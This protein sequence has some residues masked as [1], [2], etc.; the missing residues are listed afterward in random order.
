MGLVDAPA[1][2]GTTP[3]AMAA[4]AQFVTRN[5]QELCLPIAN[6]LMTHL[7]ATQR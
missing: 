1:D 6:G 5:R 4:L 3:R 2:A 7:D